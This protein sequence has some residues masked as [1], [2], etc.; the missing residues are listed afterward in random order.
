MQGPQGSQ[1]QVVVSTIAGSSN[2]DVHNIADTLQQS[3]SSGKFADALR[4][5]GANHL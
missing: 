5:N 2:Q 4:Q 1:A 3:V